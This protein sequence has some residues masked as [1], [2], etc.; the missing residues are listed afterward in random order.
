MITMFQASLFQ[1][2]KTLQVLKKEDFDL[3][4]GS[5]EN[6]GNFCTPQKVPPPPPKAPGESM[7]RSIEVDSFLILFSYFFN[8]K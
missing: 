2:H 5:K 1:Q 8:A 4:A 3:L 6:S 7:A